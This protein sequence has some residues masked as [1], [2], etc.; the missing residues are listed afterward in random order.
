MSALCP[1]D[2]VVQVKKLTD[3]FKMLTSLFEVSS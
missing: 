1:Y 2:V 3:W